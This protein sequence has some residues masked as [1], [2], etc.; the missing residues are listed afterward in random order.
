MNPFTYS[1]NIETATKVLA[2]EALV[3]FGLAF[4]GVLVL[5]GVWS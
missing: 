5:T 2:V 4:A 3:A 1:R